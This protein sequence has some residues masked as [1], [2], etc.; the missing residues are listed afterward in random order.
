MVAGAHLN[1]GNRP[2]SGRSCD[3]KEFPGIQGRDSATSAGVAV[4][5]PVREGRWTYGQRRPKPSTGKTGGRQLHPVQKDGFGRVTGISAPLLLWKHRDTLN[6][7]K[8]F[9]Y[10]NGIVSS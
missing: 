7:V 2:L 10:T 3:V 9:C 1:A 8:P 4:A 6:T 5:G